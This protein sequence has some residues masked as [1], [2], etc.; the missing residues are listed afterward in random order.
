MIKKAFLLIISVSVSISLL[1]QNKLLTIQDAVLKGRTSL[2]PKTL[3]GL[4]F[5]KG[6]GK[7]SYI[8]DNVIKIGD[9][10]TGKVDDAVSMKELNQILKKD[11]KDTLKG[12]GFI[13]WKDDK[14]F[15]FMSGK[16][17]LLFDL[18]SKKTMASDRKQNDKGLES[19]DEFNNDTYAYTKDNNLFISKDGKDIQVTNDGSYTIVYGKSVHRDEFGI[20][21]G[22]YWSPNGNYLAFYRM[23]QADV[24]DY[25]IIDWTKY[26]AENKNIKYP[27][28]GNKS[29]YVTLGIYDLK[30]GK[31]WY[32]KTEGDKEQYLTNIQWNPTEKSIYIAVLNRGQNHMKLNEYDITG[33]NFVKTLFEEK[34]EKYVEPLQPMMFVKNE[35][36]FIWFSRRDGYRHAYL[37]N[38]DGS[39][40]K[41][42][43][44]GK[45][46]IKDII[47]FDESYSRLF[48]YGNDQGPATQSAYS[49]NTKSG[50]MVRLTSG[51]GYSKVAMDKKGD[52]LIENFSS[53]YVPRE[54]RLIH[55]KTQKSITIYKAE[56]PLKDYKTGKWNLFTIKNSEGIDL[57]CRLFK[58]VDFDSTKKYPVIVYLYNGP[59]SQLVT[60]SWMAGG[61]L[62]YQYMAQKGFIVFTLDG[63]GTSYRG[64]D[65]EQSVFRQLGTKE[66]EDQLKGVDY[67][68]SLS[69]IDPNRIGVHGWS[70]GGF[71]TT[72]L[73][74]RNPGV[75]K[76]AVA[77]GPVIDWSY[78]EIM[79]TER[80]MDTPQENK[81]GYNTNNL[82][83]YVDKLKGK[84]LMIHGA[85][86]NVVVWQHSILYQKKAVDKGVLVDYYVYPGHEHNVLGKDRAHLMDKI[87]TYFIENL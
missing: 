64:K 33:G 44:K 62:W 23:D 69:Y 55:T 43:T 38:G 22:T 35:K 52:Y 26:P 2:A 14:T 53:C 79:Y 28:A 85:Q 30:T 75:F 42:L 58:P 3:Q 27:M 87:C 67:L 15:Y 82:L 80:Y 49:V 41:Q 48:F 71:M 18:A 6:S 24:T 68:K 47:G 56:D 81:E 59:H 63:R 61:E 54:Y 31:T 5:I 16:T 21:K 70:F 83:N 46:E 37:Y 74:T 78:Y 32:I 39:L 40:V 25:P 11:S 8:D 4:G 73:M 72:S 12:L 20:H 34:D 86:D 29:H 50:E 77:G 13:E 7:F 60:N 1:A 36:Q 19:Y 51:T 57:N 45:W 9:N 17:E 76:V 65:F 66:M 10:A 84:L